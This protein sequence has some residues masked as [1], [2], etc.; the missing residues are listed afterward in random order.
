[1]TEP[2]IVTTSY[3]DLPKTNEPPEKS[4]ETDLVLYVNPEGQIFWISKSL[5]EELEDQHQ[6]STA[7]DVNVYLS[8][9]ET[10]PQKAS[11]LRWTD[12]QYNAS[13]LLAPWDEYRG[14]DIPRYVGAYSD[15]A[16][17]NSAFRFEIGYASLR[18]SAWVREEHYAEAYK[19]Q[20]GDFTENADYR[21]ALIGLFVESPH[22]SFQGFCQQSG[23]TI[24][25]LPDDPQT[26]LQDLETYVRNNDPTLSHIAIGNHDLAIAGNLLNNTLPFRDA[27][28]HY[29]EARKTYVNLLRESSTAPQSIQGVHFYLNSSDDIITGENHNL[30]Y[31]SEDLE[32]ARLEYENAK[33]DLAASQFFFDKRLSDPQRR[34]GVGGIVFDRFQQGIINLIFGIPKHQRPYSTYNKNEPLPVQDFLLSFH[35]PQ[36]NFSE[37]LNHNSTQVLAYDP[38][39][40]EFTVLL[41]RANAN[42][43]LSFDD[44]LDPQQALTLFDQLWVQTKP[45]QG[46][47]GGAEW[48]CRIHYPEKEN[49]GFDEFETGFTLI[50]Q[51]LGV[52]NG[53][54][55]FVL[56]LSADGTNFRVPTLY[57]YNISH[58]AKALAGITAPALAQK[59]PNEYTETSPLFHHQLHQSASP[60]SGPGVPVSLS[61]VTNTK[62]APPY[63]LS[64]H[65]HDGD[66]KIF[67]PGESWLAGK[68]APL[69]N[70]VVID[71]GAYDSY[72]N[73]ALRSAKDYDGVFYVVTE[74]TNPLTSEIETDIIEIDPYQLKPDYSESVQNNVNKALADM[75]PYLDR[76]FYETHL[77]NLKNASRKN[78][79]YG[80][81]DNHQKD[82]FLIA[83]DSIP[84]HIKLVELR[85]KTLEVVVNAL[86]IDLENSKD[87]HGLPDADIAFLYGVQKKSLTTLKQHFQDWQTRYTVALNESQNLPLD[88]RDRYIAKNCDDL[89]K[90]PAFLWQELSSVD[91]VNLH[92]KVPHAFAVSLEIHRAIARMDHVPFDEN[93]QAGLDNSPFNYANTVHIGYELPSQ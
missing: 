9:T 61:Q 24:D 83:N 17:V 53:K 10:L 67:N 80:E 93:M 11:H 42:T 41:P 2:K 27:R 87:G 75:T 91:I 45:G 79:I 66:I 78:L 16:F 47:A 76:A 26:L 52:E 31:E 5:W 36:D 20:A 54:R 49:L 59:Y 62:N 55:N 15:R 23:Y 7:A 85:I 3:I 72:M 68:S 33:R 48:I 73:L 92:E 56:F 1:M 74:T 18:Y 50:L 86:E 29:R 81:K 51:D 32:R 13:L 90:S 30:H 12:Q 14:Y 39:K 34:A 22:L 37:W 40:K 60:T 77:E 43:T 70:Q 89:Y 35:Y 21:E 71:N 82:Y 84:T 69:P 57:V 28:A 44:L 65:M 4:S 58:F 38:R 19:A 64:G 63:M 25:T 46:D 88:E 8:Q 6:Q